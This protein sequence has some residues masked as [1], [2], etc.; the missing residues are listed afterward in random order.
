[1]TRPAC[2]SG[3]TAGSRASPGRARARRGSGCGGSGRR[4]AAALPRPIWIAGSPAANSGY[5]IQRHGP[6]V[7]RAQRGVRSSRARRAGRPYRLAWVTNVK[8]SGVRGRL[9]L[10]ISS[11]SM[12]ETARSSAATS[13]SSLR[14]ASARRIDRPV[15]VSAA[16]A[17]HVTRR[18]GTMIRSDGP[19]SGSP[20]SGNGV[21][22]GADRRLLRRRQPAPTAATRA[23]VP[24]A[25]RGS[26]RVGH[27][28]GR[29][30][31]AVHRQLLASVPA[32]CVLAD[33][34]PDGVGPV[35][36]F[37]RI[38]WTASARHAGRH[39]DRRGGRTL[40]LAIR[41]VVES[42]PIASLGTAATTLALKWGR[43]QRRRLGRGLDRSAA[44]KTV[45][46]AVGRRQPQLRGRRARTG[47]RRVLAPAPA[48]RSALVAWLDEDRLA[49]PVHGRA[50]GVAAGRRGHGAARRSTIEGPGRH[51]RIRCSR[52]IEPRSPRRP[53]PPIYVGSRS[54]WLANR[55]PAAGDR[56]SFA[57]KW[58]GTS[59]WTPTAHIVGHAVGYGR[60]RRRVGAVHEIGYVRRGIWMGAGPSTRP[61]RS[62][63]RSARCGRLACPGRAGK[64]ATW[65]TERRSSQGPLMRYDPARIT[66][67]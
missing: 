13:S 65:R 57:V 29:C 20:A 7:G 54:E 55:A 14:P 51:S 31:G 33:G 35:E 60:M 41:R 6:A 46:V 15:A 11:S 30:R 64:L 12:P 22:A 26:D 10:V 2:T 45:I 5:A 38:E 25:A 47:P 63:A 61:C 24:A 19:R 4:S 36:L 8:P 32:A 52:A 42:R 9:R 18:G 27:G 44:G 56:T 53:S 28:C 40:V 37:E 1:M 58:S 59:P 21:R 66:G 39:G 3:R 48:R 16:A 62:P 50:A 67:G 49:G 34:G 17:G 43:Q 23:A